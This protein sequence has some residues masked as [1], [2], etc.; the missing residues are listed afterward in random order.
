MVSHLI[1]SRTSD[2]IPYDPQHKKRRDFLKSN[3]IQKIILLTITRITSRK[4]N[5]KGEKKMKIYA[6][7][8]IHGSQ[9]RLNMVLDKIQE[10]SP[11]IVIICGD[12]TQFGPADIAKNFLDQIPGIVLVVPGNIDTF[13]AVR[14]IEQSHANNI[15][16]KQYIFQ[17]IV[18]VGINGV[19]PTETQS[20]SQDPLN[21]KMLKE[22]DVLVSHVPPYGSQDTVFLGRHAGDKEIYGIIQTYTPRL[23]LCGHIHE[24][25]GVTKLK[26]TVVV[27]CSIGKKGSGA[28]IQLDDTIEVTMV[29]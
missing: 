1:I 3:S 28:L 6:A 23:V 16:L 25:P 13:D 12:I 27:N 22:C 24:D 4:S 20:F 14:G 26:E 10:H 9:Y 7:A 18:F 21:Q 8:D 29:S 2:R 5:N 15:H 11:D 19:D 17:D